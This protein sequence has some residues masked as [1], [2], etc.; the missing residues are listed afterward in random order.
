MDDFEAVYKEY[1]DYVYRFLRGL[2]G[3]ETLAG[4]LTQDTFFRAFRFIGQYRGES[5][6]SVWLCSIARNLYYSH[7]RAQKHFDADADLQT[8]P[9]K[10][11][12]VTELIEDKAAAMQIHTILHSMREPYKEVFSL[13]VF[14]EL[15]F[16]EIRE[17]F[18]KSAHWA[19]VTFHRAKA[20]IQE[21]MREEEA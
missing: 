2:S 9:A 17:L 1:F 15:S 8:L 5:E 10:G 16:S 21:S 18:G 12:S 3:D 6:L 13:R 20:M 14:G 7:C 4:E 19:C 11:P